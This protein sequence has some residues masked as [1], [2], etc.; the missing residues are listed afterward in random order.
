MS[1]A[2]VVIEAV[3]ENL[4]LKHK[5][6][7]AVEPLLHVARSSRR[8]RARPDR[9]RRAGAARPERVL[10]MHYFSP[11]PQMPL[12]E[13]IPHAATARDACAAAVAVGI[14]Q[15]KT[16]IVVKDV[17]G[18]YVNRCLAPMLAEVFPLFEDGV[19]PSA[20]DKAMKSMGMPV[21]PVTLIDEV[22]AD[23]GLHV[24]EAMA[25]DPTMGCRMN[26]ADHV[27]MKAFVDKGWLGKKSGRGFFEYD[28][29]AS[30]ST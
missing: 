10:G 8:T 22:G 15:G 27:Q 23:V 21:G 19:T 26:G 2:D 20:L 3:P 7:R 14:K 18:F 1:R 4:E 6:I 16:C 5:V 24:T 12:L 30:A 17:P 28:K 11:V 25:A 13:I 29:R 9:A